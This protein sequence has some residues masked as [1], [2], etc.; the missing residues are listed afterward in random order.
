MGLKS[1]IRPPKAEGTAAIDTDAA[2]AAFIAG[3]PVSTIPAEA[4]KRKKS[5]ANYVRTTF[6]LSKTVNKQIDKL[7][8]A[9]RHF[10]ASR[11]DVVRA[12]VMAL[13]E[14][15]RAELLAI[16]EKASKSEPLTDVLDDD[17]E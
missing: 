6:S 15:E 16:L 7:S 5:K 10:R 17:D 11:S 3:A 13:L 1:L 8:L 9:P 14:L 4:R 12:G 2:A